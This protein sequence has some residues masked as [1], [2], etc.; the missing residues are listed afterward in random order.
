M[1]KVM[2]VMALLSMLTSPVRSA[3]TDLDTD[4]MQSIE[5]TNKSLSSNIALKDG[6]AATSDAKELTDMFSK[7]E[8]FFVKKGGAENA[9]DLAK[10]SKN[11]AIEIVKYVEGKNFDAA[12]D[13][14]T[15]LSRTC[16]T[17]HTF[18]K[19]E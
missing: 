3:E 2:I 14:A 16:R 13:S 18:Y 11:L 17:C 6:K 15:A 9:V 7:V 5:D 12:T 19:K 1:R 4:L 8:S 10:K